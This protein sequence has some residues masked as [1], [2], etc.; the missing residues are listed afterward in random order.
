MSACT[1]CFCFSSYLP[2]LLLPPS[3]PPTRP[4]ADPGG[5]CGPPAAPEH[6]VP[7]L[8]PGRDHHRAGP[9]QQLHFPRVWGF[10][11][12]F[13]LFFFFI[14]T[15]I[16]ILPSL[17]SFF[18]RRSGVCATSVLTSLPPSLPSFLPPSLHY[19]CFFFMILGLWPCAVL[20]FCMPSCQGVIHGCPL[21]RGVVAMA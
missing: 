1:C 8:W 21:C 19:S 12:L 18:R 14:L 15:Y 2:P 11:F 9:P 13:L 17:F 7:S 5:E 20:P 6:P 3:L 16:S 10:S 4:P